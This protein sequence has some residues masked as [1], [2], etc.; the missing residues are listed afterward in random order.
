MDGTLVVGCLSCL[1]ESGLRPD[2]F[3]SHLGSSF[4][5]S[6]GGT[7]EVGWNYCSW[8]SV[9]LLGVIMVRNLTD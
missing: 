5:F 6:S 9:L 1:F 8:V 4:V 2:L 7:L 3:E